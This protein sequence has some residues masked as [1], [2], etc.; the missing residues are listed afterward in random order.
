L[1]IFLNPTKSKKKKP[2]LFPYF[3]PSPFFSTEFFKDETKPQSLEKD[4]NCLG[5]WREG[6]I[7]I[8]EGIGFV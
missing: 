7:G 3:F 6:E 1:Y 4:E 2:S 8:V 5:F